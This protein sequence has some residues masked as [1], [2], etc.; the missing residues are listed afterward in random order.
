[1]SSMKRPKTIGGI[2]TMEMCLWQGAWSG[3]QQLTKNSLEIVIAGSKNFLERSQRSSRCSGWWCRRHATAV[4]RDARSRHCCMAESSDYWIISPIECRFRITGWK[5]EEE[6]KF[7]RIG[8]LILI[9]REGGKMGFCLIR[10]N[11]LQSSE[12]PVIYPFFNT[13]NPRTSLKSPCPS[14]LATIFI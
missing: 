13:P 2:I 14:I 7:F 11:S 10:D 6:K 3:R 9:Y 1:M 5:D 12:K 4:K 8:N